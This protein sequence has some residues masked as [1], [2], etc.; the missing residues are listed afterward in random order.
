MIT[1][2]FALA[3]VALAGSAAAQA[4]TPRSP[5]VIDRVLAC[6]SVADTAARLACYDGAV[7]ALGQAQSS[8]ELVAMDRQQVRKTR[9]SLFGLALPDLGVFGDANS[10][11]GASQIETTIR[12][13]RQDPLGKWIFDLAEGGRWIQLDSRQFISD[14][15]AGQ[16]IRIRRGA[17]GSYLANVGKQAAVR[18]RRVN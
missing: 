4:Q 5:Q 8:G 17:L 3:A 18:V 10:D 15:R 11:D 6:K 9:R 12:T 13:V 1:I 14:P 16:Q 2:R 7:A